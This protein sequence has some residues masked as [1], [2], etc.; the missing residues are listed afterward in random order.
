[1]VRHLLVRAVLAALI[2]AVVGAQAP[3]PQPAQPPKIDPARVVGRVLGKPVTAADIGMTEPIDPNIVFDSR[4]ERLW[5]QMS[6]ISQAL[7]GPIAERFMADRKIELT[8]D[9][10]AQWHRAERPRHEKTLRDHE[11]ELRVTDQARAQ[12]NLDSDQKAALIRRHK[13]LV[14]S[15]RSDQAQVEEGSDTELIRMFVLPWKFERELHR[16]Y[17]GRVIFQQFGSEALDAQRRLY[18]EAETRGDLVIDDPG[19]RHLFYYYSNMRHTVIYDGEG[20][21]QPNPFAGPP[22]FFVVQPAPEPEPKPEP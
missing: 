20:D 21:T 17:G 8:P 3:A 12:P 15:I 9:D 4:D 1:M 19:V 7:G 18:E 5:R 16:T 13:A 11:E 10:I 2:P 6:R 14:R 22:W